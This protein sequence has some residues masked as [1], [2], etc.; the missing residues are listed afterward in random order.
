MFGED[1]VPRSFAGDHLEVEVDKQR[2]AQVDLSSMEVTCEDEIFAGILRT[3]V[4]KLRHALTPPE[5][6]LIK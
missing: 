4:A 6:P 2:K 1:S 3:A 5:A